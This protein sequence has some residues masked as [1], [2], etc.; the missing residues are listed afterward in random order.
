MSLPQTAQRKIREIIQQVKQQEQKHQQGAAVS[1]HH[2][3]WPAGWLQRAPANEC[4]PPKRTETYPDKG[5]GQGGQAGQT[6]STN[7]KPKNFTRGG[8]KW[9]PK[10]ESIVCTASPVRA[11][12][13]ER[14][15][16]DL[17][18]S[19]KKLKKTKK[20]Q[21]NLNEKRWKLSSSR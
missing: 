16:T 18:K 5:Q 21:T 7:Q 15:R 2:S 13:S 8:N 17:I 9:E 3:K 14:N 19:F 6:S 1:P 4:S 11:D 12:K 20:K 10:A